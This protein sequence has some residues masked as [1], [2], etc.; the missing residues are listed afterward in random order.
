M[1]W[2]MVAGGLVQA[3][4]AGCGILADPRESA[5]RCG[6]LHTAYSHLRRRNELDSVRAEQAKWGGW[7]CWSCSYEGER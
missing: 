7:S 6:P 4:C 5:M 3:T 1:S 2:Q